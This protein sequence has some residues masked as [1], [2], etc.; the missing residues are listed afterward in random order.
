VFVI[1]RSQPGLR[2]RIVR[3]VDA[4]A[5]THR[6]EAQHQESEL[7]QPLAA[8]LVGVGRFAV[9]G[10]AHLEEDR[11]VGRCTG[12]RYIEQRRDVKARAALID[13]L[14]DAIPMALKR[15]G[16]ARIERCALRLAPGELPE[17]VPHPFLPPAD[18]VRRLQPFQ[19]PCALPISAQGKCAEIIGHASRVIAVSHAGEF[20]LGRSCSGVYRERGRQ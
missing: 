19:C 1:R 5:L 12:S 11:G 17:C 6:I 7:Y 18:G 8:A 15:S 3:V 16:N 2:A 20:R 4:F 13:K 14:F 10:M 9:G